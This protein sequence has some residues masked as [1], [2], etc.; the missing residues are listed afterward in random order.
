MMSGRVKM[1]IEMEC[2]SVTF[3]QMQQMTELQNTV[4]S[5][6]SQTQKGNYFSFCFI[7][8]K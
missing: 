7:G 4:L 5:E 8:G 6:T 3:C 2:Y 1:R